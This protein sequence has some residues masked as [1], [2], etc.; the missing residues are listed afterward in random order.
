MWLSLRM[1]S[2]YARKSNR[3]LVFVDELFNEEG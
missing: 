3:N 1:A 2:K